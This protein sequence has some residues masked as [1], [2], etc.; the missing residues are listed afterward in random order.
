[1][2]TTTRI[3]PE[4][5]TLLLS[6]QQ[7]VVITT[8]DPWTSHRSLGKQPTTFGQADSIVII[9][10]WREQYLFLLGQTFIL[11]T[12]LTSLELNCVSPKSIC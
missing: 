5:N 8:L 6:T 4:L 11:D 12:D 1:M 2:A 9:S 7:A 3:Y 10:P